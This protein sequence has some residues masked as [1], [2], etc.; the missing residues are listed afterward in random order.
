MYFAAI[1][2]LAIDLR[3]FAQFIRLKG[4]G[5]SRFGQLPLINARFALLRT[6]SHAAAGSCRRR[7]STSLYGF[8]SV[9]NVFSF[10]CTSVKG[11]AIKLE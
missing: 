10:T 1:G 9:Y 6:D 2:R 11:T 4:T 7:A 3:T 5:E 8:V